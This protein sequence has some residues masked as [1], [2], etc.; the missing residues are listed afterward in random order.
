MALRVHLSVSVLF[1]QSDALIHAMAV[2]AVPWACSSQARN[3]GP[4]IAAEGLFGAGFAA[5]GVAPQLPG[6]VEQFDRHRQSGLDVAAVLDERLEGRREH[7]KLL[8][9]FFRALGLDEK[10]ALAQPPVPVQ[11]PV[12]GLVLTATIILVTAPGA[13]TWAVALIK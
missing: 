10:A 1:F 5:D 8:D 11:R 6:L 9:G 3:G 4:E 13:V 7:F 12:L 2:I